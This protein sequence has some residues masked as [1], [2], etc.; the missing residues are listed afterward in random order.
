MKKIL[1]GLSVLFATLISA[2]NYPDSYPN[3]SW[4]NGS[5]N[6]GYYGDEEDQYYFPDDYYYQYPS[7]YYTPSYYE[8]YYNDYLRSIND[9]NWNR[10]FAT[11][12]LAPW[13]IREIIHLNQ[14]FPSFAVW[15]QYYRYN[16]DRWYYDRFY[17]L[18]R[19]LGPR[20][21][22]VFQNIYYGG[23]SPVVYYQKYRTRH[24]A[25][26]IYVVPRYRNIN[27]NVYR[28]DRDS[29]HASNPRQ[30]WGSINGIRNSNSPRIGNTPSAGN[31]NGGFR[32]DAGNG[33]FRSNEGSQPR[34]DTGTRSGG[35]RND[36]GTKES[37][38]RNAT[39]ERKIESS[40]NFRSNDGAG[41]RTPRNS[42]GNSGIRL[43]SR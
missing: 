23:Y 11:Y 6:Y 28:L 18:E 41:F 40:S 1:L 38:I 12:R 2:Q 3:N 8:A 13:Q 30:N 42:G 7:D 37:S 36:V 24:Y 25:R 22:V 15:D 34:I 26:N 33:G 14:M 4:G 39:P 35:F 20:I 31:Q 19:I 21:F 10:F 5:Q 32:N 43:T 29:Y 27:I 17:A 16:P 9:V